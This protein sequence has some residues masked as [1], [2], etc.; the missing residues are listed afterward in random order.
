MTALMLTMTLDPARSEEVLRHIRVDVIPWVR[1][2]PGFGGA[3]WI[4]SLDGSYCL[5]LVDFAEQ[6]QAESV[7]QLARAQRDNPARSWNFDRIEVAEELAVVSHPPR[8][9]PS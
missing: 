9:T 3:R 1:R 7:A 2:L 5:V 6:E 4:R 8:L